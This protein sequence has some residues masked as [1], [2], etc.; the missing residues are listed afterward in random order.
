MKKILIILILTLIFCGCN[1]L[2]TKD[3][4]LTHEEIVEIINQGNYLILDVRTKEEYEIGHIKDSLNIP[5]DEINEDIYS[6][7]LNNIKDDKNIQVT[8]MLFMP[9]EKARIIH[10][11]LSK[12]MIIDK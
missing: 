1:N 7:S 9:K 12:Y 6:D 4:N 3:L 2:E 11:L 5:Y 8:N 10:E